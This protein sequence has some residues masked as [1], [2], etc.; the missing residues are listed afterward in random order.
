MTIYLKHLIVEH[1]KLFKSFYRER[2]V[3]AKHHYPSSIR[4]ADPLLHMCLRGSKGKHDMFKTLFK[5]FK[6][7]LEQSLKASVCCSLSLGAFILKQQFELTKS[8]S[9]KDQNVVRMKW[10]VQSEGHFAVYKA[11]RVFSLFSPRFLFLF[12]FFSFTILVWT[13][14]ALPQHPQQYE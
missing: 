3:I 4:K 14:S 6:A 12:S 2:N 11:E 9:V 13:P 1:Q 5:P 10:W 8:F 7:N